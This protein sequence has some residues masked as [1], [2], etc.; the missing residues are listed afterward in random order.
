VPPPDTV[1]RYLDDLVDFANREDVNVIVQAAVT[2]AQFESSIPSPTAA[3]ASD[4]P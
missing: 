3:G 2:H 1:K 4:E